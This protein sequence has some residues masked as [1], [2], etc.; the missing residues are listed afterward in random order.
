[1]SGARLSANSESM[2]LRHAAAIALVGCCLSGCLFPHPEWSWPA[3]G[4]VLDKN[5]RTPVPR[6][7]VEISGYWSASTYTDEE[8]KFDVPTTAQFKWWFIPFGDPGCQ[9]TISA[10]G[11]ETFQRLDICHTEDFGVVLLNP[12]N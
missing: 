3:T 12:A 1:M 9:Y 8:G 5:T 11:R 4:T 7:H 6:V 10:A 2:N